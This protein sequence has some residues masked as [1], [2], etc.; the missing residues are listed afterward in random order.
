MGTAMALLVLSG[1][2]VFAVVRPRGLPEAVAAV[3]AALLVLAVGLVPWSEGWHEV[4]ALGPT[5]AFLA[6][7]L[8]LSQLAD[9][10]GVFAY[11]GTVA[12]RTPTKPAMTL[13]GEAVQRALIRDIP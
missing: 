11:A 2:L 13:R 7:V 1:V 6:A 3:P 9:R 8:V 10:E 5:V 4:R 12:A